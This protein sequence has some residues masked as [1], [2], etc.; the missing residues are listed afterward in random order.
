[1]ISVDH[2]V[3]E[4]DD[5]TLLP[6]TTITCDAGEALVVRGH[7]G[8]GK[9]TLLRVLAGLRA[10]TRGTVTIGG[11]PVARRDPAFRR[12]VAA[13]IGLPPTASDLTVW[14]HVRLVAATWSADRDTAEARAAEALDALGLEALL[15]RFPHELSTGQQ[16]LVG[17]TLATARPFEVLLLDEPEQR[18]DQER[19]AL[20]GD[21]LARRRDDGAALVVATH[22]DLLTERI[23]DRV[24][25]LGALR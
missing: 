16:Q 9:S 19:T 22:S 24:V 11:A 23:A 2:L 25:D 5:V 17:L 14:D 4:A 3:V 18:L 12:R 1:M 6:A 20:V 8:A 13:M 10:P 21:L 7:N 15:R